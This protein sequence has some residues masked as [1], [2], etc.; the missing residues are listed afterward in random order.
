MNPDLR[1]Y[2]QGVL[3]ATRRA[4][5]ELGGDG[6]AAKRVARASLALGS[7]TKDGVLAP[8]ARDVCNARG[9]GAVRS[10]LGRL[11][12]LALMILEEDKLRVDANETAHRVMR[13]ATGQCEKTPPPGERT[14]DQKDPEA[15][16]RGARRGQDT[17]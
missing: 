7:Y 3:S 11:E 4:Q 2:A 12:S 5:R 13:E 10:G 9:V 15:V 6:P 16:K 8:H 14:E 17:P 1:K